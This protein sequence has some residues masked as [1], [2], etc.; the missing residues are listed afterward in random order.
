MPKLLHINK[1]ELRKMYYEKFLVTF[2]S[3]IAAPRVNQ[4][5]LTLNLRKFFLR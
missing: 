3:D 2:C 1:K 4:E 5:N